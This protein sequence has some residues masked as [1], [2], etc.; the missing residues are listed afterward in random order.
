MVA[1]HCEVFLRVLGS[2][3]AAMAR[4]SIVVGAR[5]RHGGDGRWRWRGLA[6]PGG[7][8]G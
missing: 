4:R 5:C 7:R 2:L 8:A 1:Q 6:P 3:E